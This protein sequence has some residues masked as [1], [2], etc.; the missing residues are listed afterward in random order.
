MHTFPC[1]FTPFITLLYIWHRAKT[2]VVPLGYLPHSTPH[3]TLSHTGLVLVSWGKSLKQFCF[4]WTQQIHD[5]LAQ[6]VF[7]TLYSTSMFQ[8]TYMSF[9][10]SSKGVR[11]AGHWRYNYMPN[12]TYYKCNMWLPTNSSFHP[13]AKKWFLLGWIMCWHTHFPPLTDFSTKTLF[14]LSYGNLPQK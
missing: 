6:Q 13:H 2:V 7:F 8:I 9:S 5:L 3:I 14:C 4:W 1:A 10:F 11:E 12:L